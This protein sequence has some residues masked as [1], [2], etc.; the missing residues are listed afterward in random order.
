MGWCATRAIWT[1]TY[2]KSAVDQGMT[3]DE[4]VARLTGMT[5]RYPMDVEQ[6]GMAPMVMRMNVANLYDYLTGA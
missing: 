5:D 4:A 3:K 2:V 6:D 1:S